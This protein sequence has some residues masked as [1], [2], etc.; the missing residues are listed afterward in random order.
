MV[1][2]LRI[3]QSCSPG[4]NGGLPQ[5]F[6]VEVIENETLDNVVFRGDSLSP[7][8]VVTG[9]KDSTD[10]RVY[11]IPVN[12]KGSGQPQSPQGTLVRTLTAPQP[13]TAEKPN[14]QKESSDQD[15]INPLMV[16]AFGGAS[17][18]LL[19]LVTSRPRQHQPA[20]GDCFRW[21]V[22]LPLDPGDDHVGGACTLLEEGSAAEGE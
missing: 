13:I 15:N 2:C 1:V 18:F 11:V 22:W 12:M 21:S 6:T 17:G 8:F 4:F 7:G 16:I 3:S 9:L 10:Y 19:I 14:F 5:N 20:D